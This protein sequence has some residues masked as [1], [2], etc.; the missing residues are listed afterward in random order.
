ME[1][2]RRTQ[3]NAGKRRKTQKCTEKRRNPQKSTPLEAPWASPG[4]VLVALGR[5]WGAL[6]RSWG[7]LGTLLEAFGSLLSLSWTPLGRNLQKMKKKSVFRAPTWRPKS[8]QVGS[9][10]HKKTMSEKILI[11]QCFFPFS[12]NAS[13]RFAPRGNY[14][15]LRFP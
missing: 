1:K 12:F 9:K 8:S 5:S 6:G 2:R 15:K 14:E 3:K 11:L 4:H 10:I 13:H 7:A